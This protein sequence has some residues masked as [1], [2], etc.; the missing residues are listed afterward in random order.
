M[1]DLTPNEEKNSTIA[2]E[3]IDD[4]PRYLA[5]F[6]ALM[7][8]LGYRGKPDELAIEATLRAMLYVDASVDTTPQPADAAL[9]IPQLPSPNDSYQEQLSAFLEIVNTRTDLLP[10]A[11]EKRYR[12][13]LAL[14]KDATTLPEPSWLCYCDQCF[15]VLCGENLA[16]VAQAAPT[17]LAQLLTCLAC[18]STF[19][20][21]IY[22]VESSEILRKNRRII[23]LAQ[24]SMKNMAAE[25]DALERGVTAGDLAKT[26]VNTTARYV[27]RDADAGE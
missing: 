7:Q 17:T 2:L 25:F 22:S 26:I 27:G 20:Y 11:V 23:K 5:H 4:V 3:H 6:T 14:K 24:K 19:S 16:P 12:R 13:M 8:R 15:A 18:G 1:G 21:E 10:E 9:R